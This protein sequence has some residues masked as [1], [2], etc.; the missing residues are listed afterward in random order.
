[1][2]EDSSQ[3]LNIWEEE[4]WV[5]IGDLQTQNDILDL[6]IKK[7]E[8]YMIFSAAC[9]IQNTVLNIQHSGNTSES[10]EGGHLAGGDVRVV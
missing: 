1:V 4:S 5:T 7:L 6:P 10:E 2:S 9:W 8:C 3:M